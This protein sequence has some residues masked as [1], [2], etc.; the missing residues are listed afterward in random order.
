MWGEAWGLKG[1]HADAEYAKRLVGMRV[2]GGAPVVRAG[3]FWAGH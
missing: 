2:R 1:W 3:D